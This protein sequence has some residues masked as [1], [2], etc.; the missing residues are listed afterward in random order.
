MNIYWNY[1]IPAMYSMRSLP[2]FVGGPLGCWG[3]GLKPM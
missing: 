1:H 2:Q 3:P